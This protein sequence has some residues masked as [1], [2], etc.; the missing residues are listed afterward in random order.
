MSFVDK[1]CVTPYLNEKSPCKAEAFLIYFVLLFQEP[2]Y[3]CRISVTY[4]Y[5]I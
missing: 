1:L 4:S 2:E 3:C 5:N